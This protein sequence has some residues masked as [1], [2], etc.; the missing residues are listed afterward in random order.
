[1]LVFFDLK[2]GAKDGFRTPTGFRLVDEE[3]AYLASGNGGPRICMEIDDFSSLNTGSPNTGLEV[4]DYFRPLSASCWA[5][6]SI[7]H[8]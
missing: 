8:L 1:M 3:D 6:L 5:I 4:R 7:V 2:P